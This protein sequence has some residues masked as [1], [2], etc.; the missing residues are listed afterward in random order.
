MGGSHI[1]GSIRELKLK[2]KKLLPDQVRKIEEMLTSI[3]DYG[4]V[5]LIVQNGEL[6]YINKM[7][8][9]RAVEKKGV[10]KDRDTS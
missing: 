1:S 3:G 2:L 7:E 10:G 4:E 8:S 9:M 6:R 5:R